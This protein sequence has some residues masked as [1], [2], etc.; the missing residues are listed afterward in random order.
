MIINIYD[1]QFFFEVLGYVG[2]E[3]LNYSVG[4]VLLLM[5]MFGF[6]VWCNC[7]GVVFNCEGYIIGCG[8]VMGCFWIF[9]FDGLVGDRGS[10]V[11]WQF[12]WFFINM[13]YLVF[14]QKIV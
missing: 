14:F 1:F 5:C 9:N 6:V 10:N 13:R 12:D 2:D 4:Y 7:D 11:C 3:V 8:E